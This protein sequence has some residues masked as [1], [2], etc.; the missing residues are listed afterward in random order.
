MVLVFEHVLKVALLYML[1]VIP[2]ALYI[3]DELVSHIDLT[4]RKARRIVYDKYIRISSF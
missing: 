2:I 4:K 1:L 3:I